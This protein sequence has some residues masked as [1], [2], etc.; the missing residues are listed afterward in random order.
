[1]KP[2]P[3]FLASCLA[4]AATAAPLKIELPPETPALKDGPGKEV[5]MANCLMCHSTE[6]M[7]TQ[8]ALPAAGWKAIVV[9][10][11]EK[12]GA[13]LSEDQ[14]QPVVDYLVANYGVPTP[15]ATAPE[16]K[17]PAAPGK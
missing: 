10:M 11:R 8:P 5:V 12:F 7:T 9:K 16:A 4:L 17:P 6:Y 1:M 13:P 3:F 2:Y 15:P 14:V